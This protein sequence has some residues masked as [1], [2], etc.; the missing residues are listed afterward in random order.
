MG[1]TDE[2]FRQ[3]MAGGFRRITLSKHAGQVPVVREHPT[4]E[5]HHHTLRH[6]Q[7]IKSQKAGTHS[8]VPQRHH[9]TELPQDKDSGS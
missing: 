3:G 8:Q 7:R 5:Q 9:R 2:G 1:T 4:Q 6:S